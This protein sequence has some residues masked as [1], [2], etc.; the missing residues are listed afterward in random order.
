MK[1]TKEALKHLDKLPLGNAIRA[2]IENH[3]TVH[4][5]FLTAIVTGDLFK[6][7]QFADLTNRPL[8]A[9]Y[10]LFFT[11]YAPIDAY[12]SQEH[13]K[14]WIAKGK[15]QEKDKLLVFKYTDR[16]Y[17]RV[18]FERKGSLYCFQKDYSTQPPIFYACTPDGEPNV[19]VKIPNNVCLKLG[20]CNYLT[21]EILKAF[22]SGLYF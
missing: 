17:C 18:Y 1:L 20:M 3:R 14:Y 10:A 22:Q 7:A 9:E 11:Y 13:I 8:I 16:G 2:Y 12:G 5:D 15:H 4:G 6:A 19:S 21:D